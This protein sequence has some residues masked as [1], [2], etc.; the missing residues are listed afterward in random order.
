L[1]SNLTS[2]V[3]IHSLSFGLTSGTAQFSSQFISS[4]QVI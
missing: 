3:P 1:Q 4:P 2:V